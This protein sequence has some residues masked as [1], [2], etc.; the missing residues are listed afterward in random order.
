MARRGAALQGGG[1]DGSYPASGVI[2]VGRTLYGTTLYGGAH[3]GGTVFS[4]SR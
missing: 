3:G 2:N 4:L 1:R